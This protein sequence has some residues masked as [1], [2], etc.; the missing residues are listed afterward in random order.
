MKITKITELVS[1]SVLK[2]VEGVSAESIKVSF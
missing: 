2:I 1:A